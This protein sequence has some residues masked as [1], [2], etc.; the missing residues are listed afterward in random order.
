MS[1]A[2]HAVATP[3]DAKQPDQIGHDTHLAAA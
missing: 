3:L 1:T 2:V